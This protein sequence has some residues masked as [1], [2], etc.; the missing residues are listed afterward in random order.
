MNIQPEEVKKIV[1]RI[2]QEC[3]ADISGPSQVKETVFVEDERC[4]AR[5]YRGA[6]MMAMWL[7]A[8]HLLQFYDDNGEIVRAFVLDASA[9]VQPSRRMAA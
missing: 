3:G 2:F 7:V 9:E 6:G 1:V 5:S 8:R 4:V